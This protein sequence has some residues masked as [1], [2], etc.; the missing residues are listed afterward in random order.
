MATFCI[1]IKS[2]LV[3]IKLKEIKKELMIS[4][5]WLLTLYVE[6]KKKLKN[7]FFIWIAIKLKINMCENLLSIT[8]TKTW[9]QK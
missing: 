4:S 8:V 1:Y 6:L 7:Q 9:K 2:C 3:K 5:E